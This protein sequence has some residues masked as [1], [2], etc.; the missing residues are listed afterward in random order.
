MLACSG[1]FS[2]PA[3]ATEDEF[4]VRYMSSSGSHYMWGRED[5]VGLIKEGPPDF[6]SWIVLAPNDYK[7]NKRGQYMFRK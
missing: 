3:D 7:M 6:F 5:D 1:T 4:S 2:D